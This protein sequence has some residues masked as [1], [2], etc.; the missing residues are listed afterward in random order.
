MVSVHR[1]R[2]TE[3]SPRD[4]YNLKYIGRECFILKVLH[5]LYYT[6]PVFQITSRPTKHNKLFVYK[7]RRGQE[8]LQGPCFLFG[9][10]TGSYAMHIQTSVW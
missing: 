10:Y 6:E 3:L 8:G 2:F 7:F 9:V 4:E 1:A 5:I